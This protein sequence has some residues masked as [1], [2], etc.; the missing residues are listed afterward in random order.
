MIQMPVSKE[1]AICI[2]CGMESEMT[3][4]HIIPQWMRLYAAYF[5]L[6]HGQICKTAGLG[7][8]MRRKLCAPCNYAKTGN[9][10]FSDQEVRK[11][12]R[13]FLVLC[14]EKIK[15]AEKGIKLVV[16]CGCGRKEP[17]ATVP[18]VINP[19]KTPVTD[20][21]KHWLGKCWCGHES[22]QYRP[23]EATAK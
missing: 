13:A 1:I 12:M 6:S 14:Y 10:D 20:S 11:Y 3:K 8:Y 7:T 22:T 16:S 23:E 15:E 9:I 5:G 19:T 17:C 18:G 2:K 21:H 4:D